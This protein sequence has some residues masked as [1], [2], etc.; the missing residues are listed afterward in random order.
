MDTRALGRALFLV[1]IHRG[2]RLRRDTEGLSLLP[3]QLPLIEALLAH[4]DSTQQ[5]LAEQLHVSPA[6]IALSTKRLAKAGLIEKSVDPANQRRN[7]LRATETALRETA[8]HRKAVQAV[9]DVT[10]RGFSESE[11]AEALRLLN[12]M[13]D[14]LSDGEEFPLPPF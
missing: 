5:E 2:K 7:R 14:N 8:L 11:K 1:T 9:D 4:P 3:R 6:S 13:A 12:R 10:F